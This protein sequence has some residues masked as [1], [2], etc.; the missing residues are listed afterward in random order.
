MCKTFKPHIKFCTFFF[1]SF[2]SYLLPFSPCPSLGKS[3]ILL[4]HSIL[5]YCMF[6]IQTF[7]YRW[8][9]FKKNLTSW[10]F[11]STM[12]S[13]Q[14]LVKIQNFRVVNHED[15]EWTH[16]RH[17]RRFLWTTRTPHN[18]LSLEIHCWI[19]QRF[20]WLA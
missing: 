14:T 20:T 12:V 8:I 11:L 17:G 5:L 7:F 1:Y 10:W 15:E 2:F 6:C 4:F 9:I 19:S 16:V 3:N 13:Q 18:T